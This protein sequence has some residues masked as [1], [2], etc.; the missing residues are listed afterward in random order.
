MPSKRVLSVD[1]VFIEEGFL[2]E[3]RETT[4]PSE[5]TAVAFEEPEVIELG[6][7]LDLTLGTGPGSDPGI[8]GSVI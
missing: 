3:L 2:D 1:S 4:Q 7:L 8:A 5:H 6:N